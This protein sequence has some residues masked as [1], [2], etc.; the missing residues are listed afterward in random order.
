MK[1]VKCGARHSDGLRSIAFVPNGMVDGTT[2]PRNDIYCREPCY[3]ERLNLEP[4]KKHS[5][6]WS[7]PPEQKPDPVIERE[8]GSDDHIGEYEDIDW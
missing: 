3:R 8:P 5:D 2:V 6:R 1:C 4:K 7:P